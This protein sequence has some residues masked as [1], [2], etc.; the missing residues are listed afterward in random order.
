[1][2]Q[3]NQEFGGNCRSVNKRMLLC[4]NLCEFQTLASR[5]L[6]YPQAASLDGVAYSQ[7]HKQA[8]AYCRL[9]PDRRGRV[10]TAGT[11]ECAAA[12]LPAR[13][14]AEMSGRSQ[15]QARD[16]MAGQRFMTTLGR[17]IVRL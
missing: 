3:T 13:R 9:L 10:S 5:A 16:S 4:A 1:M 17:S 8:N 15:P 6:T 14:I 11:P 12:D 7:A 2:P